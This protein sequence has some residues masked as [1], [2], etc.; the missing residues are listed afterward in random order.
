[1][2]EFVLPVTQNVARQV[3]LAVRGDLEVPPLP[4]QSCG[5]QADAGPGVEPPVDE[6]EL[7]RDAGGEDGPKGG[8]EPT[9]VIGTGWAG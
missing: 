4:L 9:S 2:S 1:M 7:R 6:L 8:R 5:E 3:P